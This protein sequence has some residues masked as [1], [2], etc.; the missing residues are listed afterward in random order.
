M[1]GCTSCIPSGLPASPR[2]TELKI[3]G[4]VPFG[5]SHLYRSNLPF[6]AKRWTTFPRGG[7]VVKNCPVDT[8]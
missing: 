6:I 5:G 3:L 1:N 8:P 2:T 4:D 7:E